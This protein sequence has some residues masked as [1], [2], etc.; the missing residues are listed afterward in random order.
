MTM[1]EK[2]AVA[3]SAVEGF[4]TL[5]MDQ[6]LKALRKALCALMNPTDYVCDAA[7]RWIAEEWEECDKS[8]PSN[9]DKRTGAALAWE[10][11]LVAVMAE[12][13]HGRN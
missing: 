4:E 13:Q 3:M 12:G 1:M 9:P 6:R 7:D 10:D 8:F 11:M 5:T 2:A